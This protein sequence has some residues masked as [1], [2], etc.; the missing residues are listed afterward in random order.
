MSE[1]N[2]LLFPR[3]G[4]TETTRHVRVP[5]FPHEHELKI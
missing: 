2:P 3:D 5:G 1:P 4:Y